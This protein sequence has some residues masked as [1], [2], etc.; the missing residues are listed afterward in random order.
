MVEVQMKL[1]NRRLEL[2]NIFSTSNAISLHRTLCRPNLRPLFLY[3]EVFPFSNVTI[4]TLLALPFT[5]F[6]SNFVSLT[7]KI[8]SQR[9]QLRFLL[10]VI[11]IYVVPVQTLCN[12]SYSSAQFSRGFTL[13]NFLRVADHL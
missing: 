4:F 2:G 13:D 9:T 5:R 6:Y 12:S 8:R 1:W 3:F 10:I 11:I 7:L